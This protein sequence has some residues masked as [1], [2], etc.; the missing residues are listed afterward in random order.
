M[1]GFAC[2]FLVAVLT[3]VVFVACGHVPE[4]PDD[5]GS[6][7]PSGSDCTANSLSCG[8]DNALYQCD[9]DGVALSKIQ[10]CQYGCSGDHCNECAAN[11]TFC[12]ADDLVMCNADGDIVNPQTCAN[13]CQME[14]CN[15]CKPGVAYCDSA[16]AVMCGLDGTPGSMTNCGAAGC[17]SG[18]CNACQPN[19]TTCQGDTLVVCNANGN[20]QTATPCALGCGTSPNPHC[21]ALVPS[22]GVSAP[23][24]TLPDLAVTANTTLNISNCNNTPPSVDVVVGTTTTSLVGAPQIAKAT[25]NGPPICI[26]RFGRI[27][28]DAGQTL[29][30]VNDGAIGHVLSLH[31]TGDIQVNGTLT[32]LN[33]AGGPSPG[34]TVSVTN[35]TPPFTAPGAGGGGAARAGGNGGA[36]NGCSGT[37]VPA[38]AGGPAITTSST[39]LTPGSKGGNVT[40][41][42]GMFTYGIGGAGGGAVHLVSL[43]RVAVGATGRLV[44]NGKGAVGQPNVRSLGAGGGSGGTLAI[45]APMLSFSAGS[46]AVA[47]GGGAAGGCPVCVGDFIP[48]CTNADG[49]HGQLSATRAA[50]GNC[51]GAGNGGYEATG[52]ANPPANGANSDTGAVTASGGGGGGS[53]GFIILRG[54]A[55]ANVMVAGGAI[56]SPAA[57]IGAVTAN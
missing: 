21:R 45:E 28:I 12:S 13:G 25:Q 24:G 55:A 15:T 1:R 47:N 54:R 16:N 9:A 38:G 30:I 37:A 8:A 49:E 34:L 52:A 46:I 14:R 22:Y 29:T 48:T 5:G 32:F 33:N 43:T 50:G 57:T 53:S 36:C 17:V 51:N 19:T 18:V 42:D 11:T 41:S 40:S 23:S 39:V 56:V 4:V 10:D 2:Q 20:V 6:D 26:V 31:A 3:G 35:G 44:L 7:A 27:T